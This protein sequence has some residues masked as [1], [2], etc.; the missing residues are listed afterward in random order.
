MSRSS[1]YIKVVWSRPGSQEHKS[2][3]VYSVH[4][5]SA[6]PLIERRSCYHPRNGYNFGGIW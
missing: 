4:G 3:S 1:L 6:V 5:W 2:M